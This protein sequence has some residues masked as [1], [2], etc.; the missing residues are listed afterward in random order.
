[1]RYVDSKR[2]TDRIVHCDATSSLLL[3]EENAWNVWRLWEV[4][5]EVEALQHRGRYPTDEELFE[6]NRLTGYAQQR[7]RRA[8]PEAPRW[9]KFMTYRYLRHLTVK[10]LFALPGMDEY[11][12]SQLVSTSVQQLQKTYGQLYKATAVSTV[13]DA[14]PWKIPSS[15]EDAE[16]ALKKALD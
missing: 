8:Y 7:L 6:A 4:P 14:L 5:E 12:V 1:M 10:R 15:K 3:G 13:H 16:A 2:T 11:K 9:L